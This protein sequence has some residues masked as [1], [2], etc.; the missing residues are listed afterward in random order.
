MFENYVGTHLGLLTQAKLHPEIMY[1][2]T[3]QKSCDYMLVFDEVVVLVEVKSL[4]PTINV[5]T[6]QD[7]G[8]AELTKRIGHARDQLIRSAQLIRDGHP[9]FAEIPNDRPMVGLI[10][11]L[12]PFHLHQT[13]RAEQLLV[14]EELAV[15]TAWAPTWRAPWVS[16]PE[17][18]TPA[19]GCSAYSVI[20]CR[21]AGTSANRPTVCRTWRIRSSTRH[22]TGGGAPCRISLQNDAAP[23]E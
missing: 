1:G 14:S 23:A 17:L 11:T 3:G 21:G 18:T 15:S 8:E 22:T 20:P 16:S 7:D 12:E 10:V 6:G 9:A 2:P 19:P 13:G 4:R 5:R